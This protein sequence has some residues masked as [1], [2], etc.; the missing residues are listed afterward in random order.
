MYT[1][2]VVCLLKARHCTHFIAVRAAGAWAAGAYMATFMTIYIWPYTAIY[3]HIR[4]Y[5][6]IYMTICGHRWASRA[7]K[8]AISEPKVAQGHQNTPNREPKMAQDQQRS[9]QRLT[10]QRPMGG[11]R[12]P[13]SHLEGKFLMLLSQAVWARPGQSGSG[14]ARPG[15]TRWPPGQAEPGQVGAIM[16]I[17]GA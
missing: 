3:G 9:A 7:P 8:G 10:Q 12:R 13:R 15:W 16:R 2:D 14:R 17:A 1:D 5:M 6:I 11:G 4:P